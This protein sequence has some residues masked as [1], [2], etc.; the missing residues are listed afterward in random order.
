MMEI[1][2]VGLA[3]LGLF[4]L[5]NWLMGYKKDYIQIDFDERYFKEKEY[6]DA[7][8]KNLSLK[9]KWYTIKVTTNFS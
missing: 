2:I 1:I 7:F 3:G 8:Q 9:E 6:I 5:F 4:L